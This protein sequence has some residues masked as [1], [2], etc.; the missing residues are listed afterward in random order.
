MRRILHGLTATRRSCR[1]VD[2]QFSEPWLGRDKVCRVRFLFLF[3]T[4]KSIYARWKVYVDPTGA[5]SVTNEKLFSWGDSH[6]PHSCRPVDGEFRVSWLGRY[7]VFWTLFLFF[8]RW[9]TKSSDCTSGCLRG[10]G[11]GYPPHATCSHIGQSLPWVDGGEW[12]RA[13]SW[14]KRSSNGRE[15]PLITNNRTR[16]YPFANSPQKITAQHIPACLTIGPTD[17][18]D[19]SN[20]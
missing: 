13:K 6:E 5:P 7:R 18:A 17:E 8:L 12:G 10:C 4:R 2:S 16:H 1:S 9:Q 15:A 14:L 3:G 11:P 19:G 20:G